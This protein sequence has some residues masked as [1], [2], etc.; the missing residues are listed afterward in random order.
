MK[1]TWVLGAV[2]LALCAA[3]AAGQT[4]G[5]MQPVATTATPAAKPQSGR[6]PKADEFS[7]QASA[8]AHCPNDTVVWSALSKSK[9]FHLSG[10]RYFGTTKHGAYVCKGDA[11]EFGYHASKV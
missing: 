1:I 3:P 10:S 4:S 2:V 5:T 6:L 9:S 8:A 11:L 7:T